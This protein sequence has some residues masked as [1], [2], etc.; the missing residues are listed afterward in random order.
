MPTPALINEATVAFLRHHAPFSRMAAADL[1]FISERVRLAYFPVGSLLIDP[2]SG[3]HVRDLHIIQRGHVRNYNAAVQG[4]DIVLGPGECFPVG[5]LSANSVNTRHFVA[6]ED[7]FC[8]QLAKED[9]EELRA[10]SAPFAEFCTQALASIVQQSLA[11]L[12]TQFSQRA[13]EQQTLLQPLRALVRRTPVFCTSDTTIRDALAAMSREQVGTMAVVD[14]EQKPVGIFTLTDLMERVVLPGIALERPIADVMT[15]GPGVLDELA[16]A[17]AALAVMARR[18]YHQLVVT[19]EDK[20]AGIVSER[21]L[22]SLQRVS[23]RNVMQSIRTA[24]NVA[25]LKRAAQDIGMLT[26]N[27]IA[28]GAAAEGLTHTIA[29]LNDAMTERVFDLLLP[30]ADLAGLEWC[31]LSLGSEGRREQTVATDQDNAIIFEGDEDTLSHDRARLLNFA[32]AVNEALAELGFPLCPGNIMASNRECCLSVDEW[33]AKFAGWIR[34]PTPTALL[35]ANIFFDFRPLF[36]NATL[37]ERLRSWLLGI[38]R[39]NRFFLRMLTANALQAEPPLGLIRT[40]KTDDGN[41]AG[42]I[43]LKTQGTRIFVDAARTFALG[44]GVPE[45]NTTQRLWATGRRLNVEDRHINTANEAFQFLQMLRL[46]AQ[47]GEFLDPTDERAGDPG[48]N[49][50]RIDPYALNE[51]DQ[52]MLKESF[53]QARDLQRR[54]QQTFGQ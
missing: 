9:F 14:A 6:A 8:Y 27:L 24:R 38:T 40:F 18:G 32:R 30:G 1:E 4:A 48:R 54:L 43:D 19:R 22:F 29:A 17:Q 15:R 2:A 25:A 45:T 52:R 26:E 20:I 12:R 21:D 36:G 39:D 34:E 23:M 33:R 7:V 46:R 42:T 37:A 49:R 11:Q 51:L 44:L 35:N 3:V 16:D 47:R 13:A 50:N 41:N 10:R 5:S 53:R 28:Q 31:W